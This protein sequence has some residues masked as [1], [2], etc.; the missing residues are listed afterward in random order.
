MEESEG[1][2]PQTLFQTVSE[3]LLLVW[4]GETTEDS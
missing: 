3:R 2:L 4:F 1:G